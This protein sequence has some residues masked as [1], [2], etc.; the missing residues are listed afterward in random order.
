MNKWYMTSGVW[1]AVIFA[2][3]FIGGTSEIAVPVLAANDIGETVKY[4]NYYCWH[5]V[6]ITLLLMSAGMV[7]AAF[8]IFGRDVAI[9]VTALAA[10]FGLWGIALPIMVDQTYIEMPQG[11]FFATA[12]VLGCVGI[13]RQPKK[14]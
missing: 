9:L 12:A 8:S 4:L 13:L 7:R 10:A 14:A 6:S 5:L 11:W 3:H 1:L 2:A